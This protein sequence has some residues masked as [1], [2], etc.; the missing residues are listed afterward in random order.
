MQQRQIDRHDRTS[1]EN[2]QNAAKTDRQTDTI[3][4]AERMNRMQLRQ[5]DRHDR[6]SRVNEQNAA[7]TD[8]QT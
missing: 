8:R 2:E 4:Q 7:K 1:R 5:T 6:T 3:E